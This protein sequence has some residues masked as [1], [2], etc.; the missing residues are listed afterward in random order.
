MIPAYCL[1]MTCSH[2]IKFSTTSGQ[3]SICCV[4]MCGFQTNRCRH[5][6]SLNMDWMGNQTGLK[7]YDNFW[8]P[9]F[10]LFL[11]WKTLFVSRLQICQ[12]IFVLQFSVHSS[13]DWS[14]YIIFIVKTAIQAEVYVAKS[15]KYGAFCSAIQSNSHP[16]ISQK[17][18]PFILVPCV[19]NFATNWAA[20]KKVVKFWI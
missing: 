20:L 13:W 8:K 2:S 16:I 1:C 3:E 9:A 7:P 11:K 19:C 12:K 14:R 5:D 18:S 17:C 15:L 4:S 6:I 10:F